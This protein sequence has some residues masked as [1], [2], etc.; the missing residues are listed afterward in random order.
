MKNLKVDY[1]NDGKKLT[2]YL[3]GVFPKLSINAVYKALRKKDIKLN[4]KRINDNVEVFEYDEIQVFISDDI[5]LGISDFKIDKVYEDNNILVV[6]KPINVE[7]VGDNSLESK[8]GKDYSF[9]RACHRIDRNTIGLVV[10]AKNP[11]T[12]D[13]I[14][15]LFATEKIEKHYITCCY[16]IA[17]QFA[18]EYAYLFKDSKKSIVYVSDQP[19]KGAVKIHTSYKLIQKNVNKKSSLINVTLHTG[20]THQIRAHLAHIGLP[21]I[22]DGKYGSYEINKRFRVSTQLL[23]SYSIKFII[24]NPDSDLAYLNNLTISLKKIPF[25]MYV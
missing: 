22:G 8:L 5:L 13:S 19:Q 11:E 21:I 4:G 1:K 15:D 7:V 2:T 6:N 18:D 14:V 24:D 16:G 25:E 3:T 23:C 10:F 12:L 17:K 20:R 9:I